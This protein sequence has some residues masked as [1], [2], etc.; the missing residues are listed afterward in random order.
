VEILLNASCL[1]KT[2]VV[3]DPQGAVNRLEFDAWQRDGTP[4]D[5]QWFPA[6]PQG[7]SC[8]SDLD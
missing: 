8:S 2:V 7:T 5:S 4:P 3:V 6:P 1:P